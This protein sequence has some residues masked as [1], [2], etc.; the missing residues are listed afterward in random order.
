VVA[1]G[2]LDTKELLSRL[3]PALLV[4]LGRD[5]L[6]SRG[7]TDV[8]VTDGPGDGGR[9]IHSAAPAGR[10]H[11]AQAKHHVDLAQACSSAELAEL[12]M[13]CIKF[14]YDYGLFVTNARIS[15]QGKREYIDSYQSL[16]LEFLDGEE[17]ASAV[18]AD[19]VLRALW[20]DGKHI[21]AVAS[22]I[23]FPMI[24]RLHE[25]DRPLLPMRHESLMDPFM[26]L[27]TDLNQHFPGLA[28]DLRETTSS[29]Y[30][31]APYRPPARATQEEG[32]MSHLVVTEF[33]IT[34]DVAVEQ[35]EALG[36]A[37]GKGAAA[38]ISAVVGGVTVVMGR[39]FLTAVEGAEAG[40]RTSTKAERTATVG[41]AGQTFAEQDWFVPYSP[42]DGWTGE[43][44]ARVTEMS[45][46]RLLHRELDVALGY[47][48]EVAA[49]EWNVAMREITV[50]A[51]RES[52]FALMPKFETWPHASLP[53]PDDHLTWAFEDKELCGWFHQSMLGGPIPVPRDHGDGEEVVF[54][55][56]VRDPASPEETQRLSG[57]R[58]TLST[59]TGVMLVDP[60]RARHMVAL[61]G[62]DPLEEVTQRRVSIG[63]QLVEFETYSSPLSLNVREVDLTLAW[64]ASEDDRPILETLRVDLAN[65]TAA[66]A[67]LNFDE[68]YAVIEVGPIRVEYEQAATAK[69]TVL[70]GMLREVIGRA[71]ASAGSAG[72]PLQRATRQFWE[73]RH[74]VSLGTSWHESDKVYLW[75]A[76][77]SGK[78]QPVRVTPED[79]A[80][81]AGFNGKLGGDNPPPAKHARRTVMLRAVQ[82]RRGESQPDCGRNERHR[83]ST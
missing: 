78:Y 32:F 15:P 43:C 50:N 55:F 30:P 74:G 68:E 73:S 7:H 29:S 17:L 2:A 72:R 10:K 65:A 6:A 56:A 69:V 67:T 77:E 40:I 42:D 79:L 23:T 22:R 28:F 5:L 48:I 54:P 66:P 34:G 51:W 80:S 83:D 49:S 70:T 11:L 71:E 75:S 63:P 18:L 1:L 39:P 19:P 21:G 76:D 26:R 4:R 8:R 20:F 38:A 59:M 60:A 81:D 82:R 44:D 27:K 3:S 33:S 52:V 9:D 45:E 16:H 24:A 35:F 61:F 57:I 31:F 58:T 46:V 12:P 64:R 36:A 14:G 47:E 62:S 37:L 41:S 25:G 13:A 53:E